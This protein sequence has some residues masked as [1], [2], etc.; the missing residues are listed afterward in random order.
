MNDLR[1]RVNM[2][3]KRLQ[4]IKEKKRN[5]Y[6][7]LFLDNAISDPK[8]SLKNVRSIFFPPNTTLYCRSI[9]NDI[10]QNFKVRRLLVMDTEESLEMLLHAEMT[11]K[12]S[13]NCMATIDF[14]NQ[15]KF[16]MACKAY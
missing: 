5:N 14:N 9:E 13:E 4:Q 16:N 15:K 6:V 2:A 11:F 12:S 8:I 7:I 3:K 1:Y 10:I